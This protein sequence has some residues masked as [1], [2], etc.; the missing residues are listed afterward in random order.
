MRYEPFEKYILRKPLLPKE[1]LFDNDRTKI[2]DDVVKEFLNN[3][4]FV[5]SLYWS[6]PDLYEMINNYKNGFL[7]QEKISKLFNTLKKYCIRSATRCTPYGTLAGIAIRSLN[8]SENNC[9]AQVRKAN[10][11]MGL[12]DQLKTHIENNAHFKYHLKYKINNTVSNIPGQYRYQEPV[13][14]IDSERFQLSSLEKNEYLEKLTGITTLTDYTE[15]YNLFIDDFNHEEVNSFL[16]ELIEIKFLVSEL[17]I[18]L[19]GDNFCNLKKVVSKLVDH[20][21]TQAEL[22]C[23]ICYKIDNCIK[24][25]ESTPIDYIP[26]DELNEIKKMLFC[27]GISE[28]HILH[29][30]LTQSNESNYRLDRKT[31]RNINNLYSILYKL[32][33]K[34]A[35]QSDLESFRQTFKTRYEYRQVP[36][37]EVLDNEFGIGFPASVEI[38]NLN[39]NKL[40]AGHASKRGDTTKKKVV[41]THLHDIFDSIEQNG[42]QILR[43]EKIDL[44]HLETKESQNKTLSIVGIPGDDF[45]FLQNISSANSCSLLGRFAVGNKNIEY[46]CKEIT[47][48]ESLYNDDSINAELIYAPD[49]RTANIARRPKLSEFEIPIYNESSNTAENQILLQDILVSIAGDE[50]I[51]RSKKLNKKINPRLSNAHNFNSNEN[52]YYRF[53]SSLQ[54]QHE[55]NINFSIDYS[56]RS[57]RYIPRISYYNIIVHRAT[58]IIFEKDISLIKNSDNELNE[59]KFFLR[60]WKVAKYVL[61]VKGDNELFID[62]TNDSYLLLILEEIKKNK[63]LQLCEDLTTDNKTLATNEQIILILKDTKSDSVRKREE[64]IYKIPKFKRDFPPGDEWFYLKIYCNSNISDNV[65]CDYIC[66]LIDDLLE[67]EVADSIFFIRYNDPHYHL[68]IRIKLKDINSYGDVIKIFYQTLNSCFENDLIWKIQIDTYSREIERYGAEEIVDAEKVFFH[69]SMTILNLLKENPDISDEHK[70]FTS[71]LNIDFWFSALNFSIQKRLDFCKKMI[72]LFSQEFNTEFKSH[73]HRKYRDLKEDLEFFLN[74]AE[75]RQFEDRNSMISE[76]KLSEKN[77]SNYIHMSLNRWFSAEQRALELM[78]FI[79]ALKQYEKTLNN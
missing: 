12:F 40:I 66:P 10:I 50:I 26:I 8:E 55:A 27:L 65:L 76:L 39:N 49:A 13:D 56:E 30:D 25:V 64:S 21:K 9:V 38:G 42:D 67:K 37:T 43:L 1:L 46:L 20:N 54:H 34:S 75:K 41:S 31:I 35:I 59:L 68:R 19:T 57:K 2:I 62:T 24:V 70:L 71:V 61:L 16:D 69:D 79:F 22:Y 74:N 48:T 63:I 78:S 32:G 45:F 17:Q 53:L 15:I 47:A 36:L 29:V 11:D 72:E 23:N 3:E 44:N 60:K 6:S 73:I 77:L 5:A 28:K 58:W 33:G 52:N 18:M 14:K 51:L 7:K 4:N